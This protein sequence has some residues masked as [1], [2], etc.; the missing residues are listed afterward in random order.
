MAVYSRIGWILRNFGKRSYSS[1]LSPDKIQGQP[2]KFMLQVDFTK[3]FE[4]ITKLKENIEL[5]KMEMDP[6]KLKSLWDFFKYLE[7]TKVQLEKRKK[8]IQDNMRELLKVEQDSEVDKEIEKLKVQGKLV[9]KDLQSLTKAF[10]EVE[11]KVLM[12]GFML[13]NELHKDTPGKDDKTVHEFKARPEAGNTNHIEIGQN[14]GI[15]DYKDSSCYYLKDK[16]AIFELASLYHFADGLKAINFIPFSNPDFIRTSIVE[17]C[18]VN[19]DAVFT[20]KDP[21]NKLNPHYR[22]HLVGGASIYPFCGFHA[23]YSVSFSSLPL[24]YY[25]IGRQYSPQDQDDESM[26]LFNVWQRS[27]AEMFILTVDDDN[28]MME[29]FRNTLTALIALYEQL[30]YHFRVVYLN[31]SALH[32]WESLRASFQMYSSHRQKYVEVGKLSISDKYISERLDMCYQMV[33]KDRKARFM[34][35]ISGTAVDVPRLLGCVLENE[36]NENNLIIPECL[37]SRCLGY[38]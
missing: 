14:L 1:G 25:T 30:G 16:A 10:W 3:K 11:E 27:T 37:K 38:V 23:G 12:N 9:T 4:E 29:I 19:P 2:S 6:V 7:S 13:P 33:E 5:R 28:E 21:N 20:I 35:I 24:K 15:L 22:L 36:N 18:G 26:G 17:G 32:N 31:A 34:K 8:E